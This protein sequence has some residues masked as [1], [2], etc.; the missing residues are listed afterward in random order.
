M[1]FTKHW[2]TLMLMLAQNYS[3]AIA[4]KMESKPVARI[5]KPGHKHKHNLRTQKKTKKK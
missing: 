2:L 5:Q 4:G 1:I 3:P